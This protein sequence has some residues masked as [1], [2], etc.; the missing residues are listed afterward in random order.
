[1]NQC[2][3]V[4]GNLTKT[5]VSSNMRNALNLHYLCLMM[6]NAEVRRHYPF[7]MSAKDF[8]C[9]VQ[10]NMASNVCC[11]YSWWFF[12]HFQVLTTAIE[13]VHLVM[14][15]FVEQMEYHI[16]IH[17]PW[18]LLNAKIL[19]LSIHILVHAE[20]FHI[21][22][23]S[24]IL[25]NLFNLSVHGQLKL[26]LWSVPMYLDILHENL[27]SHFVTCPQNVIRYHL[28]PLFL[29]TVKH[30]LLGIKVNP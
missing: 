27:H 13:H 4:M 11:I 29:L 19:Q 15:L 1:M 23:L 24:T 17:A 9:S 6:E 26:S 5:N 25:K 18:K 16:A 2:V 28:K 7:N 14:T 10:N 20:V 30:Q 22:V 8:F 3:Q 21:R 12:F